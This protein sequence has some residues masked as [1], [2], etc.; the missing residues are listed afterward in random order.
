MGGPPGHGILR[1]SATPALLAVSVLVVLLSIPPAMAPPPVPM[2]VE[3]RALDATSVPLPVGTPI[4]A[5]IDGVDY[6]DEPAV[7]DALGSFTVLVVGDWVTD[8]GASETSTIKEGAAV[9][10]EVLFAAGDFTATTSVFQEVLIWQTGQVVTQNL[11]LATGATIP[12]PVKIQGLVP[13]PAQGGNQ[14]VF[15]CNPLATPVFASDYYLQVNRPGT[16]DGPT[17]DLTGAIPPLGQLR[18]DLGSASFLEPGGDAIK[19]VYRNPGGANAAAGGGDIVVDRVEYNATRDGTLTWVPGNTIMGD[20]P[21]PGPGRIL[22]RS[23]ECADTNTPADLVLATEPGLPPNGSPTVSILLPTEGATIAAGQAFLVTWAMSD[24]IFTTATL[25]VWVNVS[26][27]LTNVSL[28]DGGT[29]IVA[30]PWTAP[31]INVTGA[32]LRIDV[33]DPLGAR[34]SA[35]RTFNIGQ[36]SAPL[37]P[38]VLT[39]IVASVIGTVAAVIIVALLYS[40]QK[41]KAPPAEAP[42]AA[43]EPPGESP[44]FCPQCGTKTEVGATSCSNCGFTFPALPR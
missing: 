24:D 11:T 43:P 32:I 7:R 1:R 13:E 36:V 34:A 35:T 19:L 16:Y 20:A 39:I 28:V 5:F 40:R 8:Q 10:D 26:Y 27:G 15:V 42:R 2:R 37:D 41:R 33:V 18:V 23:P 38:L 31:A 44:K 4:R 3:G 21:A 22:E 30:V 14:Y 17:V 9:G 29:G 25:R 12:Q 6:S